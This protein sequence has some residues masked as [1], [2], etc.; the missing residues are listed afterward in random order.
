MFSGK[1]VAEARSAGAG[2]KIVR[3]VGKLQESGGQSIQLLM[4]DLNLDGAIE[5]ASAWGKSTGRPVYGFVSHV[6][7][8]TIAKAK[9]A[10]IDH[11][12]A[13]S[14]FVTILPELVKGSLSREAK[15]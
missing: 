9:Q 12:L 6:D 1:I 14:K 10:G 3:E 7:S 5:A 15:P 2:C 4:V 11:V 8:D 13:R